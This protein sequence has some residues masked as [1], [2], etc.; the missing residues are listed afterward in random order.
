VGNC[1]R[2][3]ER[4][5]E[6]ARFCSSC[7]TALTPAPRQAAE[8]KIVS[9]LFVDLVGFTARSDS[10]DPEDVETMLR[11]YHAAVRR[12]IERFGGTV[13]KFV[14]DAVM[15]VFGAPIAHE[16]D[17][18]RAVRA[19]LRVPDVIQEL[20]QANP[21]LDLVVRV[22]VNSGEAVVNLQ[23]RPEL[24]ESMVTGDVVNTASRL[25]QVAPAGGIV[26]GEITYRTTTEAIDYEQREPVTVKGKAEPVPVWRAMRVRARASVEIERAPTPFIGR[27]DDLALL[28]QTFHRTLRESSVQLVT[29][30]GEPGVGKS[31]LIGEFFRF[32]DDLPDITYWRHGRCISYG[33]GVTFWALGEIVK[34]HAGILESDGPEEAAAKLSQAVDVVIEEGPERDWLKTRLAALVGV[35]S[36]GSGATDRAESFAAWRAFLEAVAST[37][38]LVAI[39]EDLH[40]ADDAMLEFVEHLVDWSVGVPLLVICSARPEL[41]ERRP[42]WG[43]GKRNSTTIALSPLTNK[44]TAKLIAFLLSEAVLP[45]ETQATLL[46]RSG[47]NP[48][49]A[50]EFV[51]MLIDRGF[52]ERR[53]RALCIAGEGEIPVPDTVQAII[54]GRLDTLPPERKAILHD[55][56]VMGRVFWSGAIATMGGAEKT[57]V[58][59]GLH[60]LGRKELVRPTRRSSIAGEDEYDF[61]HA[62]VRDVAYAQIPRATRAAKHVAAAEWI[63]GIVGDRVADHAELLAHHYLQA[64][65]LSRAAGVAEDR[66]T[67]L[68][69][70]ALHSLMLAGERALGLDTVR[71]AS[72]FRRAREFVNPGDPEEPHVLAGLADATFQ[73]PGESF[74]EA[75]DAYE[76][77]IAG[78][79]R[80]RDVVAAGETRLRLAFMLHIRGDT[81]RSAELITETVDRLEPLDPGPAL[82]FAYVMKARRL[83]FDGRSRESFEWSEK[84]LALAERLGTRE[85]IVRGLQYRGWAR[86]ELGD[87]D[88]L[89]D[90][91]KSVERGLEWGL[92]VETVTG[93]MNLGDL[94]WLAEGPRAAL[95]IHREGI[96]FCDRRGLAQGGAWLKAETAWTLYELGLWDEVLLV[97]DAAAAWDRARGGTH[98]QALVLPYKA[99]LLLFRGNV[100]EAASSATDVLDLARSI[101]DLQVLVPSL[102]TAALV[103][104]ARGDAPAAYE[105]IQEFLTLRGERSDLFGEFHLLDALRILMAEGAF[106]VVR[107][108]L[109]VFKPRM[110]HEEN[111][112]LSG[113]AI[114]AESS[115]QL[116]E[117]AWLY[118]QAAQRWERFEDAIER[119]RALLG[120]GRCQLGMRRFSEAVEQFRRAEEI[121]ARLGARPL[122]EEADALQQ[123]ATALSS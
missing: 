121:F 54:A 13:E 85:Q 105:L 97:A 4:N 111:V 71:A 16:D 55:A 123:K 81:A 112:Q 63:E 79:E 104:Q 44:E 103:E 6:G 18:E 106:D 2:C 11:Q 22:A 10:A 48:L 70:R 8:R 86:C 35:S 26:V 34:A 37:R 43:G 116:E 76:R 115:G 67:Q 87:P 89:E 77:A 53:G 65:E 58:T 98:L 62:L 23:T 107:Q 99:R 1:P 7:G 59:E 113:R 93:Y 94:V 120:A 88:G 74:D 42:G 21:G 36:E 17:A 51:R 33:E 57:A 9:V 122:I 118:A 32:V 64:L 56:S 90:L 92:G 114:L 38:P 119:G 28:R 91:R 117:A 82:V 30:T 110:A 5:A 69:R 50:E 108:A 24:G 31:R 12:E 25:Q 96:A 95:T 3:G 47:G 83:M 49:Y 39:I 41:Y 52:L 14:G 15:A 45:T 19:A 46:E 80:Q 75:Q 73:T 78:F 60:E 27:E 40:W 20:N 29:I 100:D 84:A 68:Q 61:W 72:H 101:R 109:A 66:R 102:V